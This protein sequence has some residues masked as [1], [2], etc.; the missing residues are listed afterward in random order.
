MTRNL[1]RLLF[2]R[3]NRQ[4]GNA[5][6][7]TSLVLMFVLFP[8]TFGMVEFGYFF[9]VKHSLQGAAREGA[10]AA[11]VPTAV[12][13]EVTTAVN[14]AMSAAGLSGD[15]LSDNPQSIER[16]RTSSRNGDDCISH[17]HVGT[18]RRRTAP[19]AHH[20]NEQSR[21]GIGRDA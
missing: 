7:E 11:I 15:R 17:L 14:A 6:L 18:D 16:F 21:P 3:R 2:W 5:V 4:R 12:N 20:R 10:R 19:D 13:S 8:L 9:Y 1:S